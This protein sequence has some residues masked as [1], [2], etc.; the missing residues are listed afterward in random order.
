MTRVITGRL[1]RVNAH[2]RRLASPILWTVCALLTSG[3]LLRY[4]RNVRI[5]DL[6][7]SAQYLPVGK[8]VLHS[9]T[10]ALTWSLFVR[11]GADGAE[12]VAM[13]CNAL[14]RGARTGR[15]STVT[16]LGRTGEVLTD[17]HCPGV[18][19]SSADPTGARRV[20]SVM[21]RSHLRVLLLDRSGRYVYGNGDV[22][23]G[24]KVLE[25]FTSGL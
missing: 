8:N 10:D 23:T 13:V 9:T 1:G 24:T 11:P 2:L 16:W 25:L 3:S 19:S 21:Q 18:A 22:I 12:G 14:A 7:G 4:A 6:K 15:A 20:A 5:A 17:R